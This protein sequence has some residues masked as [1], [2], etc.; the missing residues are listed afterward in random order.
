MLKRF[1]LENRQAIVER[2]LQTTPVSAGPGG[3]DEAADL[4]VWS[5]I[6]HL[7]SVLELGRGAIAEP[8]GADGRSPPDATSVAAGLHE[9]PLQSL[10][11]DRLV[12][13]YG[14]AGQAVVDLAVEKGNP[15]DAAGMQ[16]LNR[17]RDQAISAAVLAHNQ[18]QGLINADRAAQAL[19]EQLGL[20]AHELRNQL[21]A[22]TA[23]VYVLRSGSV[24]IAG[25]TGAALDRCLNRMQELV[26]SSLSD[27]RKATTLS[28]RCSRIAVCDLLSEIAIPAAIHARSRGCRLRVLPADPGVLVEVDRDL[29]LSAL[30]NL[31]QNAVKFSRPDSDIH[32][33]AGA[34][35][36]RVLIEVEDHC[37]GL[38]H[39]FDASFAAFSQNSSDR[40]G[41]GLGLAISR[42]AIEANDGTL[43]VRDIPGHGCVFTVDLPL[44]AVS[45]PVAAPADPDTS[46][47][48]A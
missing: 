16:V 29:L 31:L 47:E 26:D 45:G 43:T 22:A 36:G 21:Q 5:V 14:D 32:L 34:L 9:L 46:P 41:L 13:V 18:R 15:L 2:C 12:R 17:V 24:T 30:G 35:G 6:A 3:E 19:H 44:A 38:P 28:P 7:I 37:G 42:R 25:S 27:V 1:I 4:W 8:Q 39:A 33:R 40:T 10:S 20:M 48:H 11:I 23:M